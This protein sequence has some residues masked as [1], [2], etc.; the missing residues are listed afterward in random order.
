MVAGIHL[1][2]AEIPENDQVSIPIYEHEFDFLQRT[3]IVVGNESYG[4]S[5]EILLNSNMIHV[6]M[7]GVGYCLN[8]A[9]AANVIL[10]EAARQ[11]NEYVG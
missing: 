5:S 4:I 2:S 11:Y 6:P 3:C 7:P 9:Q 1:L 8:T 10:Y